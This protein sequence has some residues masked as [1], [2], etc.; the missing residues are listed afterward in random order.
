MINVKLKMM[1]ALN[2]KLERDDFER[3]TVNDGSERRN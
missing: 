1:K 2:G 3:Q